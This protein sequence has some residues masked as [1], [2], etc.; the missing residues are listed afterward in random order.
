MVAAARRLLGRLLWKK[1]SVDVWQDTSRSDGDSSQQAVQLFVVLDSQGN[2]ARHNTRLL[3]VTGGVSS[4]LQNLGA[5]VLQDSGEVNWG[6]SSHTGGVLSLTQ[7]TSDTTNWE[8]QTCLGRCGGGLLFSTASFSFS[9]CFG[10]EQEEK[11]GQNVNVCASALIMIHSSSVL[12]YIAS[13][14]HQT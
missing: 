6:S 3:V 7:V 13:Q 12:H 10:G 4:Q 14:A 2:V 5:Q 11:V 1:N 8:L 9:C